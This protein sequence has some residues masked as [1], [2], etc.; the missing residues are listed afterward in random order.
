MNKAI[1]ILHQYITK[2]LLVPLLAYSMLSQSCPACEHRIGANSPAFFL[3][4]INEN[5]MNRNIVTQTEIE[6][7]TEEEHNA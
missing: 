5:E 7:Q 1:Y 2:I 6:T 4:E 3:Q